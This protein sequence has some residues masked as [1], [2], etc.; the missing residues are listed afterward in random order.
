MEIKVVIKRRKP[1]Q[2]SEA[3]TRRQ[4]LQSQTLTPDERYIEE[5][6]NARDTGQPEHNVG[7]SPQIGRW[8]AKQSGIIAWVAGPPPADVPDLTIQQQLRS[9]P[10]H[11][12][13]TLYSLEQM[14][15]RLQQIMKTLRLNK[16]F[17]C[18]ANKPP[19]TGIHYI[20]GQGTIATVTEIAWTLNRTGSYI[21]QILI[22]PTKIGDKTFT[23]VTGHSIKFISDNRIG[24]GSV[25]RIC[26]A[27]TSQPIIDAVIACEDPVLPTVKVAKAFRVSSSGQH[28]LVKIRLT[29]RYGCC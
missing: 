19:S 4:R 2:L 26:Q 22:V 17:I 3:E 20:R 9:G 7:G 14:E 27:G 1:G 21:P 15:S 5:L 23:R 18:A 13:F 8:Y 29:I 16:L 25:V 12:Y 11:G 6:I 28:D 24:P 10:Q